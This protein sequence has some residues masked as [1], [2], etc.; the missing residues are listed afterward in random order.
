MNHGAVH[1]VAQVGRSTKHRGPRW[2]GFEAVLERK[3]PRRSDLAL[4]GS[5]ALV[6]SEGIFAGVLKQPTHLLDKTSRC[7]VYLL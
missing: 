6:G 7:D 5:E 3:L 4:Y 1:L 2:H